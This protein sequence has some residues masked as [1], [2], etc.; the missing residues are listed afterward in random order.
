MKTKN[1]LIITAVI[2][3]LLGTGIVNAQSSNDLLKMDLKKSPA[4]DTL[5]VVFY[6]TGPS[7]NSVVTR[8]SDNKYVV[9]LP[10]VGG[11]SNIVPNLG[12]VKDLVTNVDVKNVDDGI[13]G[14]TK[15]TFNTTKP[16]KIN[17][18]VKK[19]APLTNAQKDYKNLIAQHQTTT[20]VVPKQTVST[21]KTDN[22]IKVLSAS[23]P[24]AQSTSAAKT[25]NNKSVSSNQKPVQKTIANT[26]N[27][28][29][30]NNQA[31]ANNESKYL[32][33][34]NVKPQVVSEKVIAKASDKV[35]PNTTPKPQ[36]KFDSNGKRIVDLEPKINHK[37]ENLPTNQN[38]I[39]LQNNKVN[40]KP[41][42]QEL[43]LNSNAENTGIV[44]STFATAK[45]KINDIISHR[46][47]SKKSK[48]F[49]LGGIGLLG[50]I[51]AMMFAKSISSKEEKRNAIPSIPSVKINKTKTE[52]KT[53]QYIDITK[54]ETAN[55]QEKFKQY[56]QTKE[57]LN[58]VLPKEKTYT[59]VAPAAA[60]NSEVKAFDLPFDDIEISE[61]EIDNLSDLNL[62]GLNP[63][64]DFVPNIEE[65]PLKPLSRQ[66]KKLSD[67]I[68]K[69][70]HNK[71]S[72]I[73][74][75]NRGV[76]PE[77]IKINEEETLNDKL[78]QKVSEMEHTLSQT[79]SFSPK[80]GH[81][82]RFKSEEEKIIHTAA[83]VKLK[84]FGHPKSLGLAS[85]MLFAEDK[86]L[87]L[88]SKRENK[89]VDLT[90]S[91]IS[92]SKRESQST[93]LGLGSDIIS[94]TRGY[95]NGEINMGKINDYS[96]TSL[97]DYLSI[98]DMEN[99]SDNLN[100]RVSNPISSA[101]RPKSL[102][103]NTASSGVDGL[104]IK[105]EYK[106]DSD[107]SLYHVVMDKKSAIVG[108][109]GDNTYVLKKF[110]KAIN[111][112]MQVR[113][114]NDNVYI[115]KIG[116]YKCLVDVSANHMGTLIEI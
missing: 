95:K 33:T 106:I 77:N 104:E 49:G 74:S 71:R 86:R 29:T 100:S 45:S 98:L 13:G 5:D 11:N 50:M 41:A 102:D 34:I 65:S 80:S 75:L 12:G 27:N 70:S 16:I 114:D 1:K 46:F 22:G 55:W 18:S 109:I 9:L 108:R 44:S 37:P 67:I 73:N 92:I 76:K 62:E 60:D 72:I 63:D 59:Y 83:K 28:I 15:V 81:L 79:Q 40:N 32:K 6:T 93:K 61:P 87:Q 7:Q 84:A 35:V 2:S 43:N 17:T 68:L 24:S 78:R 57:E 69:S 36:M 82:N 66:G 116:R 91:P 38:T 56:N 115:V 31:A 103:T 53:K 21:Q 39:E 8:K 4:T 111:G 89:H 30:S 54:D 113:L 51:L 10:N 94:N 14:Y 20:P 107:K 42:A 110:D 25:A 47:S 112:N 26:K 96:T 101:A 19:T 52:E 85:R 48:V 3:A 23:K 90:S 97:K 58:S 88:S 105:S 99:K 64:Q